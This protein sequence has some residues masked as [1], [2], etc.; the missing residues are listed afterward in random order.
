MQALL[1]GS[2]AFG[3][4]ATVESLKFSIVGVGIGALIDAAIQQRTIV[5][6]RRAPDAARV[7]L[8]PVLNGSDTGI[9]L[10]I[11]FGR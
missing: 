11:R 4:A 7:S 8:V 10:A 3:R 1:G 9:Q 2:D 5:Y 6:E